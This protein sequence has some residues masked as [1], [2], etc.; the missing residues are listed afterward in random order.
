VYLSVFGARVDAPRY[1]AARW[2]AEEALRASGLAW[3]IVRPA[4]ITGEDRPE[5]RPL[6]RALAALVDGG[7]VVAGALGARGLRARHRSLDATTLA[8]GLLAAALD[9]A[10][11]GAVLGPAE[12]RALAGPRAA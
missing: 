8:R 3:T 1:Y 4:F 6:E 7:L 9:P 12:I 2:R 10:A 5:R 11:A